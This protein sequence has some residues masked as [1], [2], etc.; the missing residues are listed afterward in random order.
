VQLGRGTEKSRPLPGLEAGFFAARQTNNESLRMAFYPDLGDS[1][2][3]LE[4]QMRCRLPRKLKDEKLKTWDEMMIFLEF[5]RYIPRYFR[6][7]QIFFLDTDEN[8]CF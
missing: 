1:T 8:G 5:L 7:S 4:G 2:S 6:Y 3:P